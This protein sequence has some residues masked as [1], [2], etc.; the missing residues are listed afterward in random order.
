MGNFSGETVVGSTGSSIPA[1]IASN[2]LAALELSA[3]PGA[4]NLSAPMPAGIIEQQVCS[5]SGMA[6]G[7]YCTGLT[8]EWIKDE[9]KSVCTWHTGAGLFYP[10][11]YQAWLTERFRFG[12]ARQGGSGQIRI[13]VSGSVYFLDPSI[14]PNAQAL[15]VET[16]GFGPDALL[17]ADGALAGNLNPAGVYTL[18]L[19]RGSHT[20]LVEDSGGAF[21]SVDFEVR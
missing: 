1:R 12:Y 21:A 11:E 15:R 20:V 18:P 4:G 5:L 10:P 7:Q 6:A 17:Y 13:P 2:L 14:P 9:I 3:G 8:R 16:T 19:S